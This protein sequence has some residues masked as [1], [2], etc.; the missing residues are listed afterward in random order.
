MF[1]KNTHKKIKNHLDEMTKVKR[2][3]RSIALGFAIGTFIAVLPT[4]GFNILVGLLIVF[5]FK[6]VNKF[7]LFGAMLIWNPFILT[8]VYILSYKIGNIIFESTPMVEYK[9]HIISQIY[10]FSRRFLVG[11]IILAV[12]LAIT[13]SILVYLICIIVE[14]SSIWKNRVKLV[15]KKK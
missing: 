9:I 11:N 1:F 4:P 3:N 5:L 15:D 2:S 12:I 6:K 7:S 13:S 14:K 8:P 10:N